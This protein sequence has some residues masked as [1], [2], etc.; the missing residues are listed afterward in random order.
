MDAPHIEANPIETVIA[1]KLEAAVTLSL[2]TSRMKDFY[3]LYII[4]RS[5]SLNYKE[6]LKA[7]QLTFTR[8]R[9]T[10]PTEMPVV[11]S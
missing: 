7:I 4:S 1:E 9:T 11:F 2:L 10:F 3:D 8:R 6:L 5:F